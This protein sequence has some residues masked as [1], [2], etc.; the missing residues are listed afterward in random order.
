MYFHDRALLLS[1][2]RW[3]RCQQ[4]VPASPRGSY[5]PLPHCKQRR[6]L[7][8]GAHGGG[9]V[10]TNGSAARGNSFFVTAT[11]LCF[12]TALLKTARGKGALYLAVEWLALCLM[13]KT[14]RTLI[15]SPKS[16]AWTEILRGFS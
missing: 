13:F 15:S 2:R 6:M 7:L 14:S 16:V 10:A 9:R 5:L 1:S 4:Q 12:L 11:L 8:C 3:K